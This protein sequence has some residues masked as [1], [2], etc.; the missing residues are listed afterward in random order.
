ML[1]AFSGVLLRGEVRTSLAR[2]SAYNSPSFERRLRLLEKMKLRLV[3]LEA[4]AAEDEL[5]VGYAGA[6]TAKR[7]A[8]EH[9][10]RTRKQAAS[11]DYASAWCCLQLLPARPA[12]EIARRG[13]PKT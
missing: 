3:V 10:R 2:V 1:R 9:K 11:S 13:W 4:D 7:N 6:E 12:V 5:I 8:F